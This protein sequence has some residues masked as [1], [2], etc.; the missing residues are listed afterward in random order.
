M[1]FSVAGTSG[2]MRNG[3]TSHMKLAS[4]LLD[5]YE[6]QVETIEGALQEMED[7]MDDAR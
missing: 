1:L 4:A 5:S 7:N 2:E 3:V 6:R